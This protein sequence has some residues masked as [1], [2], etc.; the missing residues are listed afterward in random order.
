[1]I[2]LAG[3]ALLLLISLFNLRAMGKEKEEVGNKIYMLRILLRVSGILFLIAEILWILEINMSA[4][5]G[6]SALILSIGTLAYTA[7]SQL[8]HFLANKRVQ[9]V[10]G[11]DG[12]RSYWLLMGFI[13]LFGYKLAVKHH[14]TDEVVFRRLP[15]EYVDLFYRAES[16]QED[17]VD[18]KYE[19]EIYLEDYKKFMDDYEGTSR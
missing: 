8:M 6:L 2:Y 3:L 15:K 14:V 9:N 17:P 12:F 1:M 11:L 16:G 13:L 4:Y 18:G 7:W 5:L 19:Y 10:I